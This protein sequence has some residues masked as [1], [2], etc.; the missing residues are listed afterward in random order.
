METMIFASPQSLEMCLSIWQQ[1]PATGII[2]NLCYTGPSKAVSF[3]YHR[4]LSHEKRSFLL[5]LIT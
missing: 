1:N 4:S 2:C 5:L 3:I